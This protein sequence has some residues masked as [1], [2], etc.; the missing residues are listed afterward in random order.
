MT[1][2]MYENFIDANQPE[3]SNLSKKIIEKCSEEG[4]SYPALADILGVGAMTIRRIVQPNTADNVYTP[5]IRILY[6]I[7][8]YFGCTV[9]E[10]LSSN[11]ALNI[12]FFSSLSDFKDDVNALQTRVMVTKELHSQAKYYPFV[13]IN[14][15]NDLYGLFMITNEIPEIQKENIK[16]PV[17]CILMIDKKLHFGYLKANKRTSIFESFTAMKVFNLETEHISLIGLKEPDQSVDS[18]TPPPPYI[19]K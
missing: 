12:P 3:L 17:G 18:I 1:K 6:P 5:N 8:D 10:L 15:H 16:K 14:Y 19:N 9:P 7:A 11:Y 2:N 13:K 4:I